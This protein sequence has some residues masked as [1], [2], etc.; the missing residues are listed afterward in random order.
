MA[1]R[2]ETEAN[3]RTEIWQRNEET[4]GNRQTSGR[5]RRWKVLMV[6]EREQQSPP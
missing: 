2:N 3:E 5:R 1:R 4:V 6:A